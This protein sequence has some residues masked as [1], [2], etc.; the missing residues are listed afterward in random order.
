MYIFFN[1]K[2]IRQYNN[3]KGHTLKFGTVCVPS[4][5]TVMSFILMAVFESRFARAGNLLQPEQVTSA[6]NLL[7]PDQVTS[8]GNLLSLCAYP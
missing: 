2:V 3:N 4:P 7:Q 5:I 6:G 8:A 1:F